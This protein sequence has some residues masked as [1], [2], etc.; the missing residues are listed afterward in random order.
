MQS[1]CRKAFSL[2]IMGKRVVT[3][4]AMRMVSFM[5]ADYDGA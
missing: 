1:P 4:H 3:M 5:T 2:E